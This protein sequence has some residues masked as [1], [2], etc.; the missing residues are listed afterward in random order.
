MSTASSA[1]PSQDRLG[2]LVALGLGVLVCAV[3]LALPDRGWTLWGLWHRE[4]VQAFAALSQGGDLRLAYDNAHGIWPLVPRLVA[5]LG[6]DGGTLRTLAALSAGATAAA[7][8]YW[9]HVARG[10]YAALLAVALLC[11][12]PLFWEVATSRGPTMPAL[13]LLSWWAVATWRGVCDHRWAAAALVL[14]CVC[15]QASLYA[16]FLLLPLAWIVLAE[17]RPRGGRVT[18][19]PVPLLL[20]AAPLVALVLLVATNEWL[21]EDTSERLGA[22]LARWL[23]RPAEPFLWGG[24]RYGDIRVPWWLPVAEWA[25]RL[26][27]FVALT[28]GLGAV[29]AA[30]RGAIPCRT[31]A[32]RLALVLLAAAWALPVGLRSPDHAGHHLLAFGLPPLCVLAA[33][34]V[35]DAAA[36]WGAALPLRGARALVIAA[37]VIAGLVP[38]SAAVVT[39][40]PLPESYVSGLQ[41]GP[42]GRVAHGASRIS[43]PPLLPRVATALQ[44]AAPEGKVHVMSN[45]WE[46]EPLLRDWA[47][48]E[49][50]EWPLHFVPP[51]EAEAVLVVFDDTLPELYGAWGD[52][53]ASLADAERWELRAGGVPLFWVLSYPEASNERDE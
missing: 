49:A 11:A 9:G 12:T 46:F 51:S 16:W 3:A 39:S 42:L 7:V 26:P 2:G 47:S 31:G 44:S 34:F 35:H 41:G 25:V 22:W 14:C 50:P 21:H 36:R 18:L 24:E 10:R 8:A 27:P 19:R 23:E 37:V 48:R 53:R 33:V 15:L 20:L 52:L 43:H 38:A 28:A 17:P 45:G 32:L 29:G 4:V 1:A 13:A 5:A 30:V 40:W 6:G